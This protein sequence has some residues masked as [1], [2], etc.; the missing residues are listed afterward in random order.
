M[1]SETTASAQ[2]ATVDERA[3]G[4]MWSSGR[5]GGRLLR[6]RAEG[7][8][9]G[10]TECASDNSNQDTDGKGVVKPKDVWPPALTAR[11]GVAS[12]LCKALPGSE[13]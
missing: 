2:A 3:T 10:V 8:T 5:H 4:V 12:F 6:G 11:W 13:G 1:A 9:A 7:A